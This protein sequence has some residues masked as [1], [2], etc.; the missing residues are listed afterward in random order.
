MPERSILV[1]L[2]SAAAAGGLRQQLLELELEHE[3]EH[4]GEHADIGDAAR[5]SLRRSASRESPIEQGAELAPA[6]TDRDRH[7]RRDPVRR[8]GAARLPHPRA[9]GSVYVNGQPRALPGGIGIPGSQVV[10]D[11]QG[12][13]ATGGQCIYWLHT[14]APDGIIHIES[15]T[16]RIYTLGQLL[17]RLAP[18]A[19][20]QP[21]R[22]RRGKVTAF[23]NG[24]PWTKDPRA[25]P[26]VPHAVVQLDVGTPACR[27]R[28][29]P[30]RDCSCRAPDVSGSTVDTERPRRRRRRRTSSATPTT[31]EHGEPD[32]GHPA[33]IV[34][35]IDDRRT[36][37]VRAEP[38][39]DRPDE[40]ARRS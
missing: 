18:A 34:D 36:D 37:E 21:G 2:L 20:R 35:E 7:G 30:G 28:R 17:R 8:H 39:P 31:T 1:A 12:P 26:L 13:V 23:V 6:S 5:R 38:D 11:P 29:S 14:H 24:K 19:E 25:I 4:A 27:S 33:D 40:R 22:G 3:F 10:A 15:P 32:H 16:Q 9:P